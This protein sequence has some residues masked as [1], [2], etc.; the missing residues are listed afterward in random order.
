MIADLPFEAFPQVDAGTHGG[1]IVQLLATPDGRFLVSAGE[2]TI[3]V[4]RGGSGPGDA[5]HP[6]L[7]SR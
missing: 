2:T 7:R 6:L 3:R 4:R 5:Q 1:C